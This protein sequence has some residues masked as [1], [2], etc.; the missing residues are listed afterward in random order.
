MI[1]RFDNPR[2]KLSSPKALKPPVFRDGLRFFGYMK[3]RRS[4]SCRML[5]DAA[6][7]HGDVEIATARR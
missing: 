3:H 4:R 6:W 5:R 7:K 1:S 2:P